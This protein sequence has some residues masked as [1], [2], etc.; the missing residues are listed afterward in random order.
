MEEQRTHY[1]P[2]IS[3]RGLFVMLRTFF[4]TI[5]A[6]KHMLNV[7]HSERRHGHEEVQQVSEFR[8]L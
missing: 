7:V 6:Y 4:E 2:I 8:V 5:S 3:E 1:E